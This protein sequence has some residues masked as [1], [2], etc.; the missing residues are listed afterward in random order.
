VTVEYEKKNYK[1]DTLSNCVYREGMQYD[2]YY[3]NGKIYVDEN[4]A[5]RAD[6]FAQYSALS[7]ISSVFILLGAISFI[8]FIAAS[9][10]GR[11]KISKENKLQ[12]DDCIVTAKEEAK[13]EEKEMDET[14]DVLAPKGI[15]GATISEIRGSMYYVTIS[16]DNGYVIKISGESFPEAKFIAYKSSIKHW[17]APHEN[18]E[19]T[20]EEVTKLINDIENRNAP[21]TVQI[22]IS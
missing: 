6:T 22:I 4:S 10:Q 16:Y 14:K 11:N 12:N 1:L 3:Y 15:S 17:E 5:K 18:E 9:I 7:R 19:L 13:E 21:G 2:M 8:Y 20:P